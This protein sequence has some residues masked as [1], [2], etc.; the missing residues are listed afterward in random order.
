MRMLGVDHGSENLMFLPRLDSDPLATIQAFLDRHTPEKPLIILDTLGKIRGTYGGNDAY[1]HDYTQMSA[2]K[3]LVDDAP[4]S[5]L[6]V[7]H[8]S[9]KAEKTDFLDSVSGTQG[10]AGAADSVLVIKRNRGTGDATLHVT[11]RDAAEGEY[12]I[13]MTDGVWQLDGD[14]LRDAAQRAQVRRQTSGLGDEM[15]ALVETVGQHPEGIKA[16]E[17][18]T[19]LEMNDN[20]VRSYLR[21]AVD[22]GR[23]LNPQ[24][25]LYTPATNA[26][27]ATLPSLDVAHVADVAHPQG[28][29]P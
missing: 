17:L 7:V 5:S 29:T 26:T 24:R 1:G 6:L 16:S 8:H 9:S 14:G 15:S 21:R 19:E 25:G 20:T 10:L 27:S 28:P 11:S 18:A 22:A 23:I 3:H 13:T 2:L 12:A 4:G